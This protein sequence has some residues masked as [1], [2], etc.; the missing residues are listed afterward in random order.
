[1]TPALRWLDERLAA[2]GTSADDMV[3]VE[4]QRQAAMNVTVRNVILSMRLLSALDW[5]DFFESVSLVDDVLR[6]GTD[7]AA[8]DFVTRDRYR[9]AIEEL[10]RGSDRTEL[11]VARETVAHAVRAG[12][13]SGAA[14]TRDERCE[15]PGY[16]LIGGG[17]PAL[18]RALGFRVPAGRRLLRLYV[19]AATPGYLGH[20]PPPDRTPAR[21][22]A[23]RRRDVGCSDGRGLVLLALLAAVPASDLAIALLNRGVAALL[24]PRACCRGSSCATASPRTSGP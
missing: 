8:L 15:D 2:Q 6:A 20:H 3:R 10:A 23:P 1:M 14:Q 9:H 22:T 7:C 13:G 24:R 19:A 5:A 11:D 17:R 16:Y 4:H 21:A 12:G 18:E